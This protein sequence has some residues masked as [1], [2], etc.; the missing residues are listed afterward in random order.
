M[1]FLLISD[2]I[3]YRQPPYFPHTTSNSISIEFFEPQ[4]KDVLE[5]NRDAIVQRIDSVQNPPAFT[6]GFLETIHEYIKKDL[7]E[8]KISDGGI[9]A[10]RDA[11]KKEDCGADFAEVCKRYGLTHS[12]G[13]SRAL[14]DYDGR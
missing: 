14:F 2:Y 6:D 8:I 5:K 11:L 1:L 12:D 3:G 7:E 10:L 9:K 13:I 4:F